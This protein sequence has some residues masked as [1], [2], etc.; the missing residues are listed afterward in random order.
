[1]FILLKGLV[2]LDVVHIMKKRKWITPIWRDPIGWS[3]WIGRTKWHVFGWSMV[4]VAFTGAG[5]LVM[6]LSLKFYPS[7][8]VSEEASFSPFYLVILPGAIP[9]VLVGIAYPVMYIYAIYRLLRIVD[10]ERSR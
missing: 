7:I 1:V 5:L 6:S 3:K 4:H 10:D 2:R 9:I 8:Q